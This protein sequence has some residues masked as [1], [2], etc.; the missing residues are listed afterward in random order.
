[1]LET[2][3]RRQLLAGDVELV[4][5][6]AFDQSETP[7][8]PLMQSTLQVTTQAEGE[9]APD[10]V[11]FAIDLFEGETDPLQSPTKFFG[12]H[13][14]PACTQQKELFADG[15][16]N[17]PFI[18]V[19]GPDRSLNQ[20]GIDN[21]ISSFPTWVFPDGT[22]HEG[23]LTLAEISSRSGVAIP[24][25]EQPTFE[26][27]GNQ[28]VQI[29]SPLHLP[30]DAYDPDDPALTVTVS[31]ANTNLLDAE[32]LSGNRSIR[33]DMATYG[34]MVFE[35]FEQRAP[36]ASGRVIEL[37]QADFYDGIIFHRVIDGFVI[38]AG[39]PTGTGSSGSTLPDFSDDFHPDLQHNT[40]G[41]LS[42]AKAGDDTN[43]S[44]F[45]ITEGPTRH[46]D[47]NHSIIGQLVEGEDV[48]EA[49]SS[50]QT[51][52]APG[53]PTTDIVIE[54]IEV[55]ND[56]ENSVIM[57]K[58]TGNG[59]GTTEVTITVTDSEN[60][61]HTETISVDIVNDSANGQP[62][63]NPITVPA[64][65]PNTEPEVIQVT[66]TD[67]E[68]DP[69]TF[70]A[71]VVS[72]S[73]GASAQISQ[74]GELTVTP[75]SGFTGPVD[76]QV[77]VR[78]G[79]GVVGNSS[80]DQ[81]TEIIRFNFEAEQ[82]TVSA[83]TSLD[84]IDASDSGSSNTDNITN[85]QTLTFVVTG[86][87]SGATVD[88]VNIANSSVVA[89]GTA[90]GTT[91]SLTTTNIAGLGEGTYSLAARQI[92]N[93][94]TSELSPTLTVFYDTTSVV[95]VIGSVTT[96]A[97]V[98]RLYQADLTSDE[99]GNGLVYALVN[100]P[101]GVTIDPGSGIISWTPTASQEG[102]NTIAV[103]A[104]DA[105]GNVRNDSF[106]VTVEGDPLAEIKLLIKDASGN[107]IDSI[108]VGQEFFVEFIGV[109]ARIGF[110]RDG[111]FAAYADILFDENVVSVASGNAITYATD[112]DSLPDGTVQAGLI[113]ELGAVSSE[114]SATFE[115]ESL[116]ATVRF[117][118]VGVGTAIIR[119][120]PAD[121]TGNDVLLFGE[122]T[123][124][125][126]GDVAYGSASITVGQTFTLSND[127]FTVAEDSG[128]TA[129]DVL[130]NDQVTSGNGTLSVIS[131][132]QPTSGG[133][134]TLD[135]GTVSFTPNADFNGQSTFTYLAGDGSG[136]QDE[137][138]VT[139]TVTSVNDAPTG[140]ADSFTVDQGSTANRLDVLANDSS[141]PDTG[142]TLTVAGVTG[143]TA[144]GTVVVSSDSSAVL[145]TPPAGFTGSDTFT[146]T[147][148][149]GTLTQ[150][151]SAT[152][153]VSPADNPPTAVDDA[154][155]IDE[156]AAEDSYDVTANDL[157]DV[158]GQ[159]FSL[160]ST[161]TSTNGA[162]VRV[163]NNQLV[164]AP[165]A[166]F[167]GT[168]EIIYTI[169]DT[170][171]G[172]AT[173]TVTFTI[174]PIN[175]APPVTD[176]SVTRIKG[177]DASTV[178]RIS[179]LPAN[180]DSG[181]SL[182]F[183]SVG[184]TSAGGT[185]EID[186][187]TGDIRY[188][189]P[190]ADFT[191]TD[192]FTFT[193]S[194]GS[195]L[196]STGTVSVVVEDFTPARVFVDIPTGDRYDLSGALRLR[197]TDAL[198]ADVDATAE[199]DA[200]TSMYFFSN[201]LPGDF[202][203]EVPALPFLSGGESSQSIAVTRAP[204]DGDTT[205]STTLG[206]LRPEFVSIRDWLGSA[207]RQRLLVAV[208]AGSSSVLTEA[209]PSTSTVSS[210]QVSLNAAG[211]SLTITGNNSAG[212]A[213]E[214]TL[215]VSDPDQ[216]QERG[217][218]GALRLLRVNVE[219]DQVTFN[220][221]TS[222]TSGA[223]GES[224]S[225]QAGTPS[226]A[227]ATSINSDATDDTLVAES[228][229]SLTVASIAE[230]EFVAPAQGAQADAAPA[231]IA[232]AVTRADVFVPP[233]RDD[234]LDDQ[235]AEQESFTASRLARLASSSVDRAVEEVAEGITLISGT[236][237]VLSKAED[238]A[239]D[240]ESVDQVLTTNLPRRRFFS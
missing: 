185:A 74:S 236:E 52:G 57:L 189:P 161:V 200:D 103:T 237:E 63:L 157:A 99:E 131:V 60:N 6:D 58:P 232:A 211:D 83:P 119:S 20:I 230:G 212:E 135:G 214:A 129:L 91:I 170:G 112:F 148:S 222:S 193:V 32:V 163:E 143:S 165:G 8:G 216:V 9:P 46:L 152:V 81:D 156:D 43:N 61:T 231:A 49:I 197:G 89:T 15:K 113:D 100:P 194:D 1:M 176:P 78:P 184:T 123:Q 217:R 190:N 145:Y 14:C 42:F 159:S 149:D 50:H 208:E 48:R 160:L 229:G 171:G 138:T 72:G 125:P 114:L 172:I 97:N 146:Y 234:S 108:N 153:T 203:V 150:Q 196:T 221:T 109:D 158:D 207:P 69:V 167:N 115:D 187:T 24:Q 65:S 205:V 21:S 95:S 87:E 162:S 219:A 218:F 164:Y 38:Q 51:N 182:T 235:P 175:D 68:A 111:V 151:V 73:A 96:Q 144:G 86:V 188:T 215:S 39:D 181:E 10:L 191:G 134:V 5:T 199:F 192:T 168:D 202:S 179:D 47:F 34:D 66:S 16:D 155:T 77:G 7:M 223:E 13:W 85:E 93:S 102:A 133:S 106:T 238:S 11:Q 121:D 206:R 33:I 140:V 186:A 174:N 59:T 116:I 25:S 35:M 110:D 19:T 80:S 136:A 120:E 169:Q 40:R 154:F 27:V 55:F 75:V 18:E 178:L 240:G 177:T 228:S 209:S 12:A 137:A 180:V 127:S 224:V 104:T 94:T 82:T 76:V 130:S 225:V 84:L 128:A 88:I 56:V 122:N 132:T 45:F 166:D 117:E 213:V 204:S 227:A 118:A 30:I 36:V 139:V 3:E 31:V 220:T 198:G 183:T 126:A 71:S 37:A 54:T 142:E 90:T 141:A 28:T 53:K 62:Y 23:I 67:V 29:G 22:R 4:S 107:E 2:L 105:A 173:G 98:G 201:V 195:A 226:V 147:L 124:I 92:V 70:F 239:M 41:V 210:P 101:S 64:T 44:Q 17:L 26:P 79:P 233:L